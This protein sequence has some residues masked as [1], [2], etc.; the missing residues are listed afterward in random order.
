MRLGNPAHGLNNKSQTGIE[1]GLNNTEDNPEDS[2]QEEENC[3]DNA[4][5]IIDEDNGILEEDA[6][7]PLMVRRSTRERRP[8]PR[9]ANDDYVTGNYYSPAELLRQIP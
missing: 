6:D 1:L 4:P 3:D 5:K 9:Y 8:N 2:K 7:E